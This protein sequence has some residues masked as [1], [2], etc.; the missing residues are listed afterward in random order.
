M[1][2]LITFNEENKDIRLDNYLLTKYQHLSRSH[3]K[4]M[5][6]QGN[7]LLNDKMV[8]AGQ[9]LKIGDIIEVF[10]IEPKTLDVKPEN[11]PIDII[12][13]DDNLAVINKPRGMVVHPAN[14]NYDNT[15]VNALMYHMKNLST[16]NGIIRPGIV[17]RIDKDTTGLLVIAKNDM[18]HISLSKQIQ[19]KTCKR[20]YIAL[21]HGNFKDDEGELQTGFKRHQKNRKQMAVYPLGEG[22]TA[23]TKYKV[24]ERFG[25]YTLL[26]FELKTGRTHQIRVH[27]KYLGHPIVG[28]ELYGNAS[29]EFKTNGQLLHAFKLVLKNPIDN[30]EMEFE[31]PIPD[32]FDKILKK[33]QSRKI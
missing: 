25:N 21:C 13:E 18:A 30:K 12:Y 9:K 5:I 1:S 19:N 16:I 22:K 4:N 31:A 8:K 32:D 23:I 33:L 2:T 15:L 27:C 7:V 24:L 10:D 11:L 17:H 28:D 14:G 20:Y 26:M 3:I 29:N 6:D